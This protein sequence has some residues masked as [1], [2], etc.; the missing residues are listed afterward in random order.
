[1]LGFRKARKFPCRDHEDF[2][3]EVDGGSPVWFV[4]QLLH[5]GTKHFLTYL[6]VHVNCP[7]RDRP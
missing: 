1:M 6:I 5:N 2:S 7:G 4:Y 3:I